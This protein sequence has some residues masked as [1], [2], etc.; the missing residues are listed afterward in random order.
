M[1]ASGGAAIRERTKL[2][3]SLRFGNLPLRCSE[4]KYPG[5][6]DQKGWTDWSNHE[7]TPDQ[8]RIE[9]HL[10][11]FVNKSSR[12]LHVG[13]GNSKLAIRFA[14]LVKNIVGMTIVPAEVR[15]GQ[16]LAIENYQVLLWNKY[17]KWH[18]GHG[19]RFDAIVD[20]NPSTFAC[21]VYHM[22]EMFTWYAESLEPSGAIFTDRTG[23]EQ[24]LKHTERTESDTLNFDS[25]AMIGRCFGLHAVDIDGSVF[26]LTQN[27]SSD[28]I[29]KLERFQYC[30][31][32][33][34]RSLMTVSRRL[35]N[36]RR[37]LKKIS[38]AR[39]Q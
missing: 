35:R 8:L 20:N 26:V 32:L 12:I 37:A 30:P 22:M 18:D 23:L 14:P 27:I 4:H 21:C 7:T 19:S 9:K 16:S 36:L 28:R 6:A 34:R 29:K 39:K 38:L 2:L 11:N 5:I 13:V 3:E 24:V 33:L 25:W 15:L 10:L 1:I 17:H 31:Q